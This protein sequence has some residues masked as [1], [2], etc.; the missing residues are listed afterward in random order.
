MGLDERLFYLIV[1]CII[2]FIIG[3]FSRSIHNIEEKVIEVDQI[4]KKER[5][6]NGF[7]RKPIVSDIAII[8]VVVMTAFAA[9]SSQRSSNEVRD[10]QFA[11]AKT[12]A[13]LALTTSCTQAYLGKTIKALNERTT[14]STEQA[15]KNVELQRSQ[16]TL[17]S[18]F[19]KEP[20]ASQ[21]QAEAALKTYFDSLSQFVIVAG[22]TAEK[23]QLFPYP[24]DEEFKTCISA[25]PKE[26]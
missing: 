3:W 17:L 6:E 14:Y 19:L 1:G 11:Q 13:D 4:V 5:D 2:G 12:A 18:I 7:M 26:K 20:E 25:G 24:T 22:K 21:A 16:V 23:A 9:F 10:N 15:Q 8:L